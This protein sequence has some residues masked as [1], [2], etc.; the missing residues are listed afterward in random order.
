VVTAW[1]CV[2]GRSYL[3]LLDGL[4]DH[5]DALTLAKGVIE[6]DDPDRIPELIAHAFTEATSGRAGPIAVFASGRRAVFAQRR[7]R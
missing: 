1:F 2:P 7:C 6:I 4:Y 5:R 3:P